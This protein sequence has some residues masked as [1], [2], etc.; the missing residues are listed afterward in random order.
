MRINSNSTKI[1]KMNI[2]VAFI[3]AG[4][5]GMA[6]YFSSCKDGFTEEDLLNAQQSLTYNVILR[7]VATLDGIEGAEVSIVQNGVE[8]TATT[9]ALGT[10]SFPNVKIGNGFPLVI[11]ATDFATVNTTVSNSSATYRQA[12]LTSTFYTLSQTAQLATVRGVVE[13][14]TDVTNDVSENVTT[15]DV[16]AVFETGSYN[17]LSLANIP[18]TIT[19]PIGANGTYQLQLP[20]FGTGVDYT[21][22]VNDLEVNQTIAYN[23]EVGDPLFP[24]TLPQV[25]NILTVFSDGGSPANI[26]FVPSV[27]ATVNATPTGAGAARAELFVNINTVTGVVTGI[28]VATQGFGYPVSSTLPVTITSLKGGTGATGTITTNASG[29][30]NFFSGVV[31]APGSGYPDNA[32]ANEIGALFPSGLFQ[33]NFLVKPGDIRVNDIYYGTGTSRALDIE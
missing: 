15:G 21:I 20:T 17:G 18:F 8:V 23:N 6:T 12:E 7:N 2:R 26:P 24:Q 9:N 30:V 3:L 1:M 29:Q 22:F 13:I 27:F 16:T 32:Q 5:V 31:T 14:D 33:N 25:A 11:T 4:I 28:G 10:A 19:A